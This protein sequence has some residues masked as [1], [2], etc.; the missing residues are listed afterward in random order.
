[1]NVLEAGRFDQN[2]FQLPFTPIGATMT[3][4][5]IFEQLSKGKITVQE[6]SKLYDALEPKTIRVVSTQFATA[7]EFLTAAKTVKLAGDGMTLAL[8]PK[9]FSTGSYGWL[10]NGELVVTLPDGKPVW[11]QGSI[12]LVVIGS[13][14]DKAAA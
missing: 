12:N 5:E 11:V 4:D 6:A 2:T 8:S 7:K 10:S 9:E 13:K 14:P 1:M 3:R